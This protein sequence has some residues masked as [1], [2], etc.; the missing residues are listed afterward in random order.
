MFITLL[1]S[2]VLMAALFLLLYAGVALIQGKRFFSSAPKAVQEAVRPKP[3]RFRGQHAL[4]WVLAVTALLLFPAAFLCGAW[5]GTR[6]GFTFWQFVP[7][8][9]AMLY[10]LKAFDILVFDW[11][12][13]CHGHFFPRYYPEVRPVLGPR[14]FGYNRK[15]H[16]THM[17][18]FIPAA[19]L[20][21]WAATM[22]GRWTP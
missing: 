20:M 15:E 13:L 6:Q 9:A 12:L 18:L 21:A 14:L 17:A 3:E 4:G 10:P 11:V 22:L 19:L 2:A 8:F 5:E 7:R 1:L 16:L